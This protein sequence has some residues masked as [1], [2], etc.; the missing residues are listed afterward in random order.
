LLLV[1]NHQ[2]EII[3]IISALSKDT[4]R[5]EGKSWT[6]ILCSWLL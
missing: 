4:L 6:N 5:D 3:I 2:V 1:Q